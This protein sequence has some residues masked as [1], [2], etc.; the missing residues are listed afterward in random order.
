MTVITILVVQLFGSMSNYKLAPQ[1]QNGVLDL[2]GWNFSQQGPVPL[3]GKWEFAWR[4]LNG[5]NAVSNPLKQTLYAQVPLSWNRMKLF[6]SPLSGR[7][8]AT[9]RLK[10]ITSARDS[11]YGIWVPN[12]SS[13]YAMWINGKL[14]LREGDV[15]YTE[16]RTRPSM[17]QRIAF[18]PSRDNETEIVLQ[19][20]NFHHFRGGI[21]QSLKFGQFEQISRKNK[22]ETI[23]DTL[24][25]SCLIMVGLYHGGLFV[26]R[27]KDWFTLLFGLLCISMA[28]RILTTG[29]VLL[30]HW[31][32]SS[33][34]TFALRLEYCT[35]IVAAMAGC[36]YFRSL[37]REDAPTRPFTVLMWCGAAFLLFTIYAPTVVFSAGLIV[38]QAYLMAAILYGL[39]VNIMAVRQQRLGAVVSLVGFTVLA[40]LIINDIVY[41]HEMAR[42]RDLAPVGLVLCMF[43]QSLMISLRY[44]KAIQ[45]VESVSQA[46]KTLN[47]GLEGRIQQRTAEF[48]KINEHLEL[49]N[50][51][52]ERMENSKRHLF[53]N[54]SH[55]LRTPMTLIRGYLEAFQDDVITDK[56][57]QKK[58]V[59]LML[60]KINGLNHLIGELFELSKLEARQVDIIKEEMLLEHLI[61]HLEENYDL[62]LRGRGL[63]FACYNLTYRD[64]APVSL[65]VRIDL[66]RITQ[67]FDNIIYN[68][69]KFTPTGGSIS[70]RFYYESRPH[71]P[72]L[73]IE[74]TDTGVGME[75]EHLPYIFERFYKKDQSRN[76]STGGSGL[77]LA[78]AKEIVEQHAGQIG[79]I[80]ELG[81]GCTIY[82]V[83]PVYMK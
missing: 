70:I 52:L 48:I 60:A 79:A 46:L 80:S 37:F 26:M 63:I 19:V 53:S 31:F 36:G 23:R 47:Y 24:F 81:Q 57:E 43:I 62:E 82:I 42:I 12:I 8:Y 54:I 4:E 66:D 76:S 59:K 14:S 15:S 20:A 56:Q 58:Y 27:R 2:R 68:A 28:I 64:V 34:W 11:M 35:T 29:E 51:E 49:K 39:F 71:E 41:Y 25:F 73:R 78:I 1:A 74:V 65:N 9:Y 18:I 13:S 7:G 6:G 69:V 21:W 77:G 83:L 67:V 61:S 5:P 16:E 44:S 40:V 55:D 50:M 3:N 32:P 33:S 38:Y 45:E 17:K 22:S 10:V 75:M 72:T 30:N